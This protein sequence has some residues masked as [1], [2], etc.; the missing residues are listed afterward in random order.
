MVTELA[1]QLSS[2]SRT[3]PRCLVLSRAKEV[4]TLPLVA[5]GSFSLEILLFLPSQPVASI[6]G[7]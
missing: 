2:E 5:G 7:S 6:R 3:E 1:Q 4:H